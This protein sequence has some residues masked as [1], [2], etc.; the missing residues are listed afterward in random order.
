MDVRFVALIEQVLAEEL[1]Q[2]FLQLFCLFVQFFLSDVF[3]LL[4]YFLTIQYAIFTV[5]IMKEDRLI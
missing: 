5:S 4:F 2:F 1:L 3:S